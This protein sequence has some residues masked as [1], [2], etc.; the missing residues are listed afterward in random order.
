GWR[1][2]ASGGPT[3]PTRPARSCWQAMPDACSGWVPACFAREGAVRRKRRGTP[4]VH[5]HGRQ[6]DDRQR[7]LEP[8]LEVVQVADVAQCHALGHRAPRAAPL[9]GNEPAARLDVDAYVGVVALIDDQ[10]GALVLLDILHE[11]RERFTDDPEDAAVPLVPDRC[12]IW[13]A[14]AQRAE[15]GDA[16]ALDEKRIGLVSCQGWHAPEATRYRDGGDSA[17]GGS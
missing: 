14:I 15:F 7:V 5:P 4:G 3:C 11:L 13:P 1:S 8:G 9:L 10:E 12:H 6:T 17:L 16:G 2:S